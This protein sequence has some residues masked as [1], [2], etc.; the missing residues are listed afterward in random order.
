[1][2]KIKDD[3]ELKELEKFGFRN[4]TRNRYIYITKSNGVESQMYVDLTPCNNNNN[5]LKIETSSFSIPEKIK[6][7]LYDL[8]KADLVEKV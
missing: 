2:L 6:N 8:I 4:G 7:K 1:M 3:I 5:E